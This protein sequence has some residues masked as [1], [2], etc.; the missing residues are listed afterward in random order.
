M[1]GTYSPFF[2]IKRTLINAATP[3]PD[4]RW[5]MFAFT[6]PMKISFEECLEK[7]D[8]NAVTSV[9]SPTDVPVPNTDNNL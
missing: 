2:I 8:P 3:A 4:S 7:K 5:P 6:E 9:K 1:D